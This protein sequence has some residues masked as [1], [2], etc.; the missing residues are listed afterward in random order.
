M[1]NAVP[2]DQSER[3]QATAPGS[4][5]QLRRHGRLRLGR[6]LLGRDTQRPQ[7]RAL[8]RSIDLGQVVGLRDR[9]IIAVLYTAA[10]IGAV[11]TLKIESLE[12]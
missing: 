8:L 10:C 7:T 1:S 5:R 9:A 3:E 4:G 6:M 2:P 11:A 12:A